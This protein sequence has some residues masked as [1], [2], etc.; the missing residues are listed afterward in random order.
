MWDDV[1]VEEPSERWLE[2]DDN[3][4]NALIAWAAGA[5]NLR[6]TPVS[7]EGKTVDVTTVREG[8]TEVRSIPF[9]KEDRRI[10]DESVD[11]Y[12]AA[13]GVPPRPRGYVWFIRTPE[14]CPT[15]R[16]FWEELTAAINMAT[17]RISMTPGEW[18]PVIDRVVQGF[19]A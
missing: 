19:Y 1:I 18:R 14:R 9:T 17:T 4:W 16:A 3:G 15:S 10:I 13:A 7:D 6:R 12:L 2:L 11:E 8:V 5:K